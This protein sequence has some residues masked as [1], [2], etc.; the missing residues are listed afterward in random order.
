MPNGLHQ[1]TILGR[2]GQCFPKKPWALFKPSFRS[3]ASPPQAGTGRL[4]SPGLAGGG[5]A[6]WRGRAG[7]GVSAGDTRDWGAPG[8]GALAPL[9]GS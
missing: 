9:A 6:G 1:R 4:C 2:L 7:S 5:A 8:L 3:G